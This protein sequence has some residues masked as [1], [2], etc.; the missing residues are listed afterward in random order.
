M[1]VK[2]RNTFVRDI[3]KIHDNKLLSKVETSIKEIENAESLRKIRNLKKLRKSKT[4]YRVR[5]GNY[6]IGFIYD[7]ET[8][9]LVNFKHRKNIYKQFP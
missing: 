2:Y 6:R 9:H 8:V 7:K 1:Q 3:N 4:P 5:I